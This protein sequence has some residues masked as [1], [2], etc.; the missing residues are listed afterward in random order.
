MKDKML[1]FRLNEER[2]RFVMESLQFDSFVN[3]EVEKEYLAKD[4][5]IYNNTDNNVLEREFYPYVLYIDNVFYDALT[6]A[7]ITKVINI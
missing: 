3:E 6:A 7:F 2:K 5:V 4:W 1:L